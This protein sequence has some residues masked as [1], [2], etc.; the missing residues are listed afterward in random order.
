MWRSGLTVMC[1]CCLSQMIWDAKR[2]RDRYFHSWL[3]VLDFVTCLPLDLVQFPLRTFIP[4]LRMAKM[5]RL[6][7]LFRHIELIEGSR[8]VSLW[9]KLSK[10]FFYTFIIAHFGA[11]IKY[12]VLLNNPILRPVIERHTAFGRYL[13]T[14][15]WSLGAMVDRGDSNIPAG[16]GDYLLS[17]MC[18]FL[19]VLWTCNFAA[20]MDQYTDSSDFTKKQHMEQF[21]QVK[22]FMAK[23]KL[24]DEIQGQ[25]ERYYSYLWGSHCRY[26]IQKTLEELPTALQ[27]E[28]RLAQWVNTICASRLFEGISRGCM[29]HILSKCVQQVA[30]PHQM[31]CVRGTVGVEMFFLVDG[32]VEILVGSGDGGLHE[33]VI[34]TLSEGDTVGEF[35]CLFHTPRSSSVRCVDYCTLCVLQMEDLEETF[36]LFD[37]CRDIIEGNANR[38]KVRLDMQERNF[39]S[40]HQDQHSNKTK[41]KLQQLMQ[42]EEEASGPKGETAWTLSPLDKRYIAWESLH[43]LFVLYNSAM[44]PLLIAFN[45]NSMHPLLMVLAYLGDLIMVLLTRRTRSSTRALSFALY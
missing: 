14:L 28:V 19:G 29:S 31:L 17:T 9:F 5:L 21:K 44:T 32:T 23:F 18:M 20:S 26:D 1:V 45:P 33:R 24:N 11:C 7:Q 4:A 36:D 38:T 35:A 10:L 25:V 16:L 30:L 3:F 12:T 8:S 37:E 22:L 40:A 6:F 13:V 42:M 15:Y 41:S 27:A 2:I 43:I 34:A 39:V